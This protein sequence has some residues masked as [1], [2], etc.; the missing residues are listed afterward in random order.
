MN[1]FE[2]CVKCVPPERHPG[3]Q[4]HCRYYAEGKA[5]LDRDKAKANKHREA[6]LYSRDTVMSRRDKAAKR[7]SKNKGYRRLTTNR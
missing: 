6:D 7:I 5:A 4:D 2:H 1:Y 3:C